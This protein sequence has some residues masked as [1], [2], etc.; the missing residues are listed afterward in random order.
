MREEDRVTGLEVGG[1][2]LGVHEPLHLIG[3]QD[4]DDVGLGG[5]LGRADHA[6]P[7]GLGLGTR[8]AALG[9]AHPH[10]DTRVAQVQRVG[11]ALRP[12]ADDGHRAGLDDR[13]VGIVV[14]EHFCHGDS[15]SL[16]SSSWLQRAVRRTPRLFSLM[17]LLPRLNATSPDFTNSMI[18]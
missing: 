5:G 14:I 12:V 15:C 8:L 18:P 13:Q 7:L 2:R 17:D 16:D 4:H 3:H 1:D 11:V 10:I 9:Q 6:Q